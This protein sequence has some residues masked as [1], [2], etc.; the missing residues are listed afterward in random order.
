VALF[1][2]LLVRGALIPAMDWPAEGARVL[3]NF[4]ANDGGRPLL[5]TVFEGEGP[6]YSA[7]AGEIIFSR[8]AGDTASPLPSPLGSWLALDHG[9]GIVSIYSRLEDPGPRALPPGPVRKNEALG[10]MGQ[11]GWSAQRG[12]YFSLFDRRERRWVNPSMII[13]PFE[14]TRPPLVQQVRLRNAEGQLINPGTSR[15]LGQGRYTVY[16]EAA[17]TLTDTGGYPL[18][19][20]RLI[21]SVNG[22]EIGT[23]SFET[24]SAR[25]GVLMAHRNGL[26]PAREVYAPFPAF[27]VGE[28]WLTRGQATLEIIAQDIAGNSRNA[29]YRLMVE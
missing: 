8:S 1:L 22:G 4:G 13:T 15:T 12:F 29:L 7:E 24:Y 14:D 19:P 26:V 5:G 9:D 17:D 27:E 21:C 23:L 2:A 25:D 20:H 10:I 16:V 11:T 6:V 3:N 18:A 28:L